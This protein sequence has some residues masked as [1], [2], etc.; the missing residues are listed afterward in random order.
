M[1][2]EPPQP[3]LPTYDGPEV[4]LTHQ[5]VV[6]SRETPSQTS[7]IQLPDQV[8]VHKM[9]QFLP[10]AVPSWHAP[11]ESIIGHREGAL[12]SERQ[13]ER[14]V[15]PLVAGI[16]THWRERESS[17]LISYLREP[18]WPWLKSGESGSRLGNISDGE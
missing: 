16:S 3:L 5:I 15:M 6:S 9:L 4:V 11:K 13:S 10:L 8:E 18:V 1:T 2:A 7:P 12:M 14:Q 17:D